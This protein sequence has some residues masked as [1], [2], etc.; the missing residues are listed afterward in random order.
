[1]AMALEEMSRRWELLE[2]VFDGSSC[3][4]MQDR[5]AA[6]K[7][8]AWSTDGAARKATPAYVWL[9]CLGGAAL[10]EGESC[11]DRLLAWNVKGVHGE[12]YGD[13]TGTFMRLELLMRAGGFDRML[14]RLQ[15]MEAACGA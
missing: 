14:G 2:E 8:D 5:G 6:T 12:H 1:M 7:T 4:A 9:E 13:A 11:Y 10:G 15:A 3:Y